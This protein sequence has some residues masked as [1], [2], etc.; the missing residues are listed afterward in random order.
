M[1]VDANSVGKIPFAEARKIVFYLDGLQYSFAMAD[2]AAKR[3]TKTLDSIVLRQKTL[4][5]DCKEE[6]ASA[7]LDAWSLVDM[8]HRIRE[9]IH[10]MPGLSAKKQPEVRI[11]LQSTGQVETLRNYVQHFR[12]GIPKSP[13]PSS[14]LWGTLSWSPTDDPMACYTIFTGNIIPGVTAPT[15]AFDTHKSKFSSRIILFAGDSAIDLDLIAEQMSKMKTWTV[16]WLEQK[17]NVKLVKG[18][19]LIWSFRMLPTGKE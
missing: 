15:L 4:Q 5:E 9:L 14:P 6:V 17:K 19:T 3:L 12:N 7:L 16:K 11:F 13:T 1:T 18:K 2:I 10:G 8:C